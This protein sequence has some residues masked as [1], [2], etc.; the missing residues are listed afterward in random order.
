MIG[1]HKTYTVELA[2][3]ESRQLQQIVAARKSCQ[4]EAKRAKVILLSAL[5]T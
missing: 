3:A 4:S 5:A 2:E 1:R